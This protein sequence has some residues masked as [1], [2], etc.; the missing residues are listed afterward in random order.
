MTDKNLIFLISQPRSGSTLTQKLLGTHSEIYTRSEPWIMLNPLYQ[1]KKDGV[2]A[3]YNKLWEFAATEDFIVNLPKGGKKN[4]IKHLNTM[5]LSLYNEYL[6]KEDRS[7][8]LDKTPRYYLVINELIEVFPKAIY[9]LLLRN[10]LAILGSIVSSWTKENWYMLS[11]YKVDLIDGIDA[12]L[13]ASSNHK[14]SIHTFQ[15]ED[16]L[17]NQIDTL[18]EIFK[19]IGLSFEKEVLKYNQKKSE[20]W[21][22]GDPQNIYE[23]E[24]IDTSNDLKWIKSLDNPQYW[25]VMHDYLQY[26]GKDKFE[27]LGY[28]FNHNLEILKQNIPCKTI[29]ELEAKTFS[30]LSLLNDTRECLIKNQQLTQQINR[31]NQE[32]ENKKNI[33]REQDLEIQAIY[34]S[35]KYKL[36]NTIA[37]PY[38]VLEKFIKDK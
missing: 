4:Y 28:D 5:Y 21:L 11:N 34:S 18:K 13:D 23:K 8:F 31:N 15:Y 9:I 37:Y 32:L 16:L 22:Y 12:L 25:R 20:K 10:P 33:I 38:I 26:I 1:L 24:G 14:N 3:E 35:K 19:Y 29:D 30:L 36:A 17:N 2:Y 27:L 7:Y 6:K